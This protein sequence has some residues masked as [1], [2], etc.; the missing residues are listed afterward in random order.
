MGF[1][2]VVKFLY[3][4]NSKARVATRGAGVGIER[5]GI[6]MLARLDQF[7]LSAI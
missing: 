7:S 3:P 4:K 2:R 6:G 1:A 5:S